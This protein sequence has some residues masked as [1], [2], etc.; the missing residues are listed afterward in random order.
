M[1]L[2]YTIIDVLKLRRWAFGFAVIGMNSLA[3][4]TATMLFNFRHIGNIFVGS[5][6]PRV[7]NWSGLLEASAG[8][9]VVWLILYWMYRTRSFVRL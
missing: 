5:L 4:Y 2:F 7:G 8:F 3:V 1:G 6:L 9:A